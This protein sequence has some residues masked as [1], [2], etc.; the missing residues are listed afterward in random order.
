[1]KKKIA[2]LGSTG[3]IGKT[4]I[5]IIKRDKKNF[6]IVLLSADENYKELL[7]QAKFFKVKNIIITNFESFKKIKKEKYSN[8]INIF[9]NFEGFEKIFQKKIDYTMSSISGIQGLKPTLEIIKYTNKIAIANKEAIICGWDLIKKSLNKYKTEFIPVD[10]EH[11]SVWYALKEID[12]KLIDQIYLTASGGPFLD[13]PF[14]KLKRVNIKQ[15]TNHPNWKMGRKISIDS[16]TMINKV[17]EVIEAKKIFDI[18]YNKLSIIIHPKSYVHAIVKLNNGLTKIIVHDTNMKIPIFNS[19]YSSKRI[20]NSKELDFRI[21]NNLDFRK[22]NLKKFQLGRILK[23]LPDDTSLFETILVSINDKLVDLFLNNK[24]KFTD[25]S[26]KMN[27]I[28]NLNRLKKFKNVKP[29]NIEEIIKMNTK[30]KNEI[31]YLIKK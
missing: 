26:I 20:I 31:D 13:K 11:F 5:N 27:K 24:I 15:A 17:F 28:L 30:I 19:L 12:K 8:K 4:L 9:N 16:A 10:S 2:I 18:P 23:I 6:K 22:V 29:K 14:K 7:N 25:I 21:L 3:S 1:M